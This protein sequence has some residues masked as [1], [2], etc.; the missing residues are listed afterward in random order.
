MLQDAQPACVLSTT[1]IAPRLPETTVQLQVLLDDPEIALALAQSPETNPSD[2]ERIQPLNLQ[3]SA[4]V[5]FTSGSTGTPKGVVIEHASLVNKAVTLG[6]RFGMGPGACSALLSSNT[7]D[8]SIEQ[9]AV[10][11]HGRAVDAGAGVFWNAVL[12]LRRRQSEPWLHLIV[13]SGSSKRRQ[14]TWLWTI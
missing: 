12:G 3:N 14:R 1:R 7:F 13:L 5:I 4:Y 6:A 11:L 9:V 8:P 2:A 10:P